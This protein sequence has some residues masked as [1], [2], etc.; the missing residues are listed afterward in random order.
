M[1]KANPEPVLEPDL[2]I[3]D[4]HHHLWAQSPVA[5]LKPYPPE[6]FAFDRARSGHDRWGVSRA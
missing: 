1:S 5:Y 3:I 2:P 6:R 4:V